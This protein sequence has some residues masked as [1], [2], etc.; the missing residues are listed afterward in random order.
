MR[1]TLWAVTCLVL[2]A[3]LVAVV[4]LGAA[5]YGDANEPAAEKLPAGFVRGPM[6]TSALR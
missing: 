1:K 6:N 5:A 3:L 2:Q 4:T